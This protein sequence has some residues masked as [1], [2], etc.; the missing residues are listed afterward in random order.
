[1]SEIDRIEVTWTAPQYRRM[2]REVYYRRPTYGSVRVVSM[3]LLVAFAVAAIVL[4][5]AFGAPPCLAAPLTLFAVTMALVGLSAQELA[6]RRAWR[7]DA[8]GALVRYELALTDDALVYRPPSGERAIP[9]S[10][11]ASVQEMRETIW[12]L[13]R[14]GLILL[15]PRTDG[16]RRFAAGLE[17]RRG[18]PSA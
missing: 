18:R 13:C 16:G 8:R 15:L 6:I 5:W 17:A 12:V 7:R 10:T 3:L 1:M 14:D 11:I 9:L 4:V 2:H